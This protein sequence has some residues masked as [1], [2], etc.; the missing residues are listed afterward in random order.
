MK[1]KITDKKQTIKT[2]YDKRA[3]ETPEVCEGDNV[4]IQRR[5]DLASEWEKAV[6]LRKLPDRSAR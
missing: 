1:Q 6:I 2:S 4:F 3:K 5:P